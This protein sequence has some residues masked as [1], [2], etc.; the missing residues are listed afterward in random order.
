MAVYNH[1]V[2]LDLEKCKGCT[3]C[4]KRCPTEAIRIR[5]GHATIDA[6]RCIDC[7]ECIRIC[8]YKAKKAN[9]DK[10]ETIN[11]YKYK[12]ALPAPTLYGQF[13]NLD[14][15]DY[16]LKGLLDYGFDDVFEVACAAE[17]VSGYTRRYLKRD[18]VPK[19][20]ISSACPVVVRLISLRFPYLC[21]NVMP[22][23]P[24]V[25]V[26]G[27]LARERAL[28]QHPELKPEDVCVCFISPC[29]AKVSYVKNAVNGRKSNIDV[30]V[31]VSDVYFAILGLL[32]KELTPAPV[33]RTGMI[34]LSWAS[35][36]GEASAIFNDR[37]L[38]ADGIEN[39]IRVLEELDNGTFPSLDFIELNACNGGCVGGTMTV[40]NPYIAKARLQTL[41]RYLPVSQNWDFTDQP[42]NESFIPDEYVDFAK[43]EYTPADGL[44]DDMNEAFRLRSDIKRIRESL[45]DLDCGSCGAPT[46]LAF[47]EDIIKGNAKIDDCIVKM[48][49][50]ITQLSA[51][52][53]KKGANGHDGQ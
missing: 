14:D 40:E 24:P 13:D 33:S 5:D 37:Y 51:D 31:S 15:I 27:R 46:C 53:P 4:L 23:L 18:D 12:I 16:L 17:I 10:L 47:A 32:K 20:V 1:S 19:P 7:G 8:P 44:S 45:P 49:E 9:Y 41:K 29:P 38:A 6:E 26:A 21:D 39:V 52:K 2:S 30:V 11:E 34:G 22:L 50:R 43:V 25:E 28:K 36:G 35:A 3:N 42:K 48:R